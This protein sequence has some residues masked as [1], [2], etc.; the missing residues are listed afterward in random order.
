[1]SVSV[2]ASRIKL[3]V[4]VCTWNRSQ[5]LDAALAE[6][7]KL[8]IPDGLEWELLVVNNNS[9]DNTDEIIA[10]HSSALPLRR[11]FEKR[12]GK[13]IAANYGISQARGDLIVCTDDDVLVDPD[14]V[15]EYVGAAKRWPDAAYFGG[16]IDPYFESDPPQWIR[17]YLVKNG[18]YSVLQHGIAVR[19]M[20]RDELGPIGANMAIR[21]SVLREFSFDTRLGPIKEEIL[22]ADDGEFFFRLKKAGYKGV[23]VGTAKVRHR[24]AADLLTSKYVWNWYREHGRTEVRR[25]VTRGL[26][27]SF[28]VPRWIL[29]KYLSAQLTSLLLSPIKGESWVRAYTNAARTSGMMQEYRLIAH[30]E[31]K[32]QETQSPPA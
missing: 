31:I 13:S 14:W 17:N 3:T 28:G 18:P 15:S 16:T 4:M 2:Q 26:K 12:P 32:G 27:T 22:P 25:G 19:P 10:R 30:S 20:G 11:L 24:I 1:M 8:K 21:M 29:R 6:M 7:R 9:T 23:W 5:Y